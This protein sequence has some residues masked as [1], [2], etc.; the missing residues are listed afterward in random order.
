MDR[1]FGPDG[2]FGPDVPRRVFL[3]PAGFPHHGGPGALAWAIFALVLAL[4]VGFALA[5]LLGFAT[6]RQVQWRLAPAGEPRFGPPDPLSVLS[7]RYARGEISRD[8]FVQ[9][10]DDL[11]RRPPERDEAPTETQPPPP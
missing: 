9:T 1:G 5:A 3:E 4:V 7:M 8:Q 2:P 11:R 10:T 6:R